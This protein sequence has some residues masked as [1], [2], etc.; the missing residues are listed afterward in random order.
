MQKKHM[1]SFMASEFTIITHIK[2]CYNKT[3]FAITWFTYKSM[4]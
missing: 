4:R 2:N 3:A 1:P